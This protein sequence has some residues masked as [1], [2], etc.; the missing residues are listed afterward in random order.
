MEWSCSKFENRIYICPKD[1]VW[2]KKKKKTVG[3]EV[4]LATYEQSNQGYTC[5]NPCHAARQ[6]H[7][8]D[9]ASSLQHRATVGSVACFQ[10]P[11]I[12]EKQRRPQCEGASLQKQV[13]IIVILSQWIFQAVWNLL[14]FCPGVVRESRISPLTTKGNWQVWDIQKLLFFFS[15]R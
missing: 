13:L 8:E 12:C 3:L 6:I 5:I 1:G 15:Q 10:N 9:T 14:A 11:I 2:Q 4:V 7:C